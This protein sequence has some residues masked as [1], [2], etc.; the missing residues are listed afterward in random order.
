MAI[1]YKITNLINRK[2]Y[3][4]ET[5]RSFNKRWNEHKSRSINKGHGYNYHLH[6]AMRKY[7]FENFSTEI[8]EE[9]TDDLRFEREHFYILKYNSLEPNGYNFL[10]CGEGSVKVPIER[11]IALWEEGLLCKEIGNK[12]NLHYQ[13][14]SEHLKNYGITQE[15]INL[16]RGNF[17]RDRCSQPVCQYDLKG[18]FIKEYSSASCTEF[19]QSAISSV[20]LQKQISAYGYLWKYKND[21]RPIQEWVQ[22]VENK[23][24]AGRPK[25]IVLQYDLN[26][27]L[28]AEYPS[29]K[30]AA[31]AMG[32]TSRSNLCSAARNGNKAYG[33]YWKYK[34]KEN[35]F[36]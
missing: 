11:I 2:T 32:K 13:T 17:T 19:Q 28:I 22:R 14:V 7:G 33:Y 26:M 31:L 30:E 21:P 24:D 5:T 35:E 4:G 6:C 1:I 27:N 18:N 10:A 29:A 3:I 20:C 16:R 34:E 8:L 15:E 23:K 9:C 12:L 36:K 25:K